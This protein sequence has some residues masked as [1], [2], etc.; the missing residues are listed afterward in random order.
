[1]AKNTYLV[2]ASESTAKPT[3]AKAD[4]LRT[5]AYIIGISLAVM[6]GLEV[7][8]ML[9]GQKMNSLG[10]EPRTLS[11]LIGIPLAPVLH[12]GFGHLLA[13]SLPF[14]ILGF[15]TIMRGLST[16]LVVST[17]VVLVGGLAVWLV[18]SSGYHIGASGLIFGYFGYNLAMGIFERSLKSIVVSVAVGLFYGTMIFGVLPGRPGVSWEGHLF[19][20]AAGI[21]WAYLSGRKVR[22]AKK[23]A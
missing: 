13:N 11:G 2:T 23:K 20:A 21:G 4:T 22:A 12:G 14:V 18:G 15:L 10:N 17:V 8:D 7:I 3:P 1:M 19:G 16:F 5:R 9:I 6:W